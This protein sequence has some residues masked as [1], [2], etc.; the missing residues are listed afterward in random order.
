M[1]CTD[2]RFAIMP[3]RKSAEVRCISQNDRMISC[4]EG[5]HYSQAS[6]L[7]RGEKKNCLM[8]HMKRNM[9]MLDQ[10]YPQGVYG[11]NSDSECDKKC[12]LSIF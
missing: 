1:F 2:N 7:W 10:R 12:Y 5:S 9:A 8:K 4:C 11:A 6:L 3:L